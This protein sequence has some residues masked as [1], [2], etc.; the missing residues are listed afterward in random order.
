M[1]YRL[2]YKIWRKDHSFIVYP[3]FEKSLGER[4]GEIKNIM[5]FSLNLPFGQDDFRKSDLARPNSSK[6]VLLKI[7]QDFRDV[8]AITII[9]F[10][11]K[12]RS[13]T[14]PHLK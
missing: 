12:G 9:L 8:S 3:S 5:K 4:E 14:L 13:R 2:W 10:N 6:A 11:V 7:F 1:Y